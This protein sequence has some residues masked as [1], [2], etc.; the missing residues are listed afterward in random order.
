LAER[1][2]RGGLA[3]R[4]ITIPG[5][6]RALQRGLWLVLAV[7][8][9]ALLATALVLK[10]Q[11]PLYTATMTVAP[12]ETDLSA[13]S[14]LASQLEQFARLAMLAQTPAKFEQVSELERYVQMFRSTTLAARLRAEHHL[15]QTIFADDWD[16]ERQSWRPP[17]G[18]V[19][20]V[21]GAVLEFF[22]YP[23][24]TPPNEVHLAEWLAEE[25]RV[26]QLRGSS[27]LRIRLSHWSPEFARSVIEMVHQ[28]ADQ[29]LREEA[30]ARIGAQIAQGES[31]LNSAPTPTRRAALE[32]VLVRQ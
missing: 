20:A 24:W 30:L 12:A 14:Q 1:S 21:K 10:Q 16:A 27:L 7:A 32:E 13:A 15:L 4:E 17:S 18:P 26:S 2:S 19:A 8:G 6:V 29:I 23:P 25:V 3:V 22:G 28:A 9:L 31:E 11:V 5:L